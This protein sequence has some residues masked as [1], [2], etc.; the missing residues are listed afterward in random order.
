LLLLLLLLLLLVLSRLP[1]GWQ[2]VQQPA[3][4]GTHVQRP[5]TQTANKPSAQI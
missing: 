1:L 2:H 3:L 4:E 5:E